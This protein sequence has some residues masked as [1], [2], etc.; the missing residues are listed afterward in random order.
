MPR[1]LP[2]MAVNAAAL[3]AP[4]F[5]KST[6]T[7]LAVRF[8]RCAHHMKRVLQPLVQHARVDL[9]ARYPSC[10][11]TTTGAS[12]RRQAELLTPLEYVQGYCRS[13]TCA[14]CAGSSR[15]TRC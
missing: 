5:E 11:A 4:L 8:A 10:L 12:A 15:S 1:M 7:T 9:S 2:H 13:S 3:S 14:T 6:K